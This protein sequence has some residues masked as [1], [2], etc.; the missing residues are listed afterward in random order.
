MFLKDQ[1]S[2][3][4]SLK[5]QMFSVQTFP[6]LCSHPE[7]GSSVFLKMPARGRLPSQLW[8]FGLVAIFLSQL[9]RQ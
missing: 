5:K 9:P 1:D 7:G 2:I 6:P 3:A 4:I 8:E